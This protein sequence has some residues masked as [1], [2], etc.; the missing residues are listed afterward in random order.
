[1]TLLAYRYEIGPW[2]ELVGH[3]HY[4]IEPERM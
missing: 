4:E 2:I 1:V 3:G